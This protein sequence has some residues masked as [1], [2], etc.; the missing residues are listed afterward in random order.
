MRTIVILAFLLIG[1]V[2][3][4]QEKVPAD[5][6]QVGDVI[7]FKKKCNI[8]DLDDTWWTFYKRSSFVISSVDRDEYGNVTYFKI[9]RHSGDEIII[10]MNGSGMSWVIYKKRVEVCR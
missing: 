9:V 8:S 5:S 1:M 7:I 3:N 10:P 6:M 2:S 4:A